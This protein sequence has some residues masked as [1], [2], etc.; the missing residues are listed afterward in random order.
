MLAPI[1]IYI[2]EVFYNMLAFI[3]PPSLS[4]NIALIF[5]SSADI[6]NPPMLFVNY[7]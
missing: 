6:S 1:D 3:A 2:Y 4:S 7:A 5:D